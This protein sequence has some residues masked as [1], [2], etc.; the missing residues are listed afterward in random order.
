MFCKKC[1]S[2]MLPKS[3]KGLECSC[4]Y[5]E[6]G[7]VKLKESGKNHDMLG[8]AEDKEILPLTDAICEKCGHTQ[9]Y[10]WE[11]QTRASDEPATRFYKCE[12]CKHTWREYK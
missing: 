11:V 6:S 12:K 7:N 4:G 10:T 1:G 5:S 9:A 8:I 3:G 2:I